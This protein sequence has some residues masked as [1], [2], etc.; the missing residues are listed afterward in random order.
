M[1][2]NIVAVPKFIKEFK[3]LFKRYPSLNEEFMFLIDSLEKKPEQGISLG[4]NC[5]KIRLSIA[6]KGKGKSGGARVITNIVVS[7]TTVYLLTI[8]DKSE[9]GDLSK[10]ELVELL[11][12]IEE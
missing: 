12:L 6:S 9:K 1:N 7:K 5:F 2:Y 11:K 3:K 4:K 10:N 8:Y